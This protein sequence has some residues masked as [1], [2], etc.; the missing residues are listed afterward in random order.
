MGPSVSYGKKEEQIFL[1]TGDCAAPRYSEHTAVEIDKEVKRIVMD[2]YHR[3]KTLIQ[4]REDAL[5][6]L[7]K[8]F[9]RKRNP[10]RRRYRRDRSQRPARSGLGGPAW[11]LFRHCRPWRA[12]RQPEGLTGRTG[13][14][15][16]RKMIQSTAGRE[17]IRPAFFFGAGLSKGFLR[18]LVIAGQAGQLNG[19]P[20]CVPPR[21]VETFFLQIFK[22][23]HLFA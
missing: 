16:S 9:A 10:G 12:K 22:K 19:R 15:H 7:A 11:S 5:H 6:G 17:S 18:T 4:E 21:R 8:S 1:G 13:S 3:A 2:N 20:F 14:R 23:I